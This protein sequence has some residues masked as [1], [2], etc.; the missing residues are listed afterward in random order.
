MRRLLHLALCA[1]L[2]LIAGCA[3]IQPDTQAQCEATRDELRAAGR[4]AEDCINHTGRLS[5][6]RAEIEALESG[7]EDAGDCIERIGEDI[8]DAAER[9]RRLIELTR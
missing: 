6:C 5:Q 7:F 1:G 3:A 2:T 9:V 8:T 4:A